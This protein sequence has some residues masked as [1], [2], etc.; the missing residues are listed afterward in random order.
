[1]L[2]NW[3]IPPYRPVI[4]CLL[5][6]SLRWAS[7]WFSMK[8]LPPLTLKFKAP[9]PKRH[10]ID[11]TLAALGKKFGKQFQAKT[12]RSTGRAPGFNCQKF[13]FWRPSIVIWALENFHIIKSWIEAWR[14]SVN[15]LRSQRSVWAWNSRV[16]KSY[17]IGTS[18]FLCSRSADACSNACWA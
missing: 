15:Y 3:I 13:P 8:T 11:V 9:L 2:S 1:M 16:A 17:Q 5:P 12:E 6:V 7:L 4:D 10:T 18:C 14:L